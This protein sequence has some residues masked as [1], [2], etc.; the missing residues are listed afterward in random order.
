MK[1]LQILILLLFTVGCTQKYITYHTIEKATFKVDE[2]H[3][4]ITQKMY[5]IKK[6]Q[7]YVC[8]GQWLFNN[9]AHKDSKRAIP[10]LLRHTCRGK[11]H[12]LNAKLTNR[13]WTTLV[14]SRSCYMVEATCPSK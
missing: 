1:T 3:N 4:P 6:D 11:S 9:N 5:G 7:Q 8:V 14:Y 12:L 10:T 13:W 2:V